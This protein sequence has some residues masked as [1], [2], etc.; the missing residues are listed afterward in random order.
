M[1]HSRHVAEEK[2]PITLEE[3]VTPTDYASTGEFETS[4]RRSC[5]EKLRREE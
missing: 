3:N 4:I 1:I 5:D 2:G